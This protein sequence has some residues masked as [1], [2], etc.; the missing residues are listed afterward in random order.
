MDE[1]Q[2]LPFATRDKENES[3]DDQE[4]LYYPPDSDGNIFGIFDNDEAF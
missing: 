1:Y 3:D 2:I 4:D